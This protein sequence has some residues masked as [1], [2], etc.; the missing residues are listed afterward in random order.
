MKTSL[1]FTAP[2]DL[3]VGRVRIVSDKGIVGEWVATPSQLNMV[4]EAIEPGYYMAEVS[5]AGMRP[6]SV[7]FEVREGQANTVSL[8]DYSALA[9]TGGGVVFLDL[10]EAGEGAPSAFSFRADRMMDDPEFEPDMM[11]RTERRLA[12]PPELCPPVECEPL[13]EH[14]TRLL[15]VAI[16]MERQGRRESWTRFEGPSQVQLSQGHLSIE[17]G[18]PE[19]WTSDSGRRAR[20]SVAIQGV[21]IERLLLPLYRGGTVINVTPSTASS[22]D[23]A[24]EVLP[25]DPHLRALWRALEA[26]TREHAEAVRDQL[27]QGRGAAPVERLDS[28]DPWEAMLAGLLYLR[29]PEVFGPLDLSWAGELCSR[30][31]WAADTHIIHAQQLACSAGETESDVARSAERAIDL[32]VAAQAC[33]SPY[34]SPSNMLFNELV[35]SLHGLRALS[36]RAEKRI[37]RARRRWQRELPLQRRAGAS[38]S[39]LSRDQHLLKTEG[40]LAPRRQT[41]GRLSGR[42][43]TTLFTGRIVAG[44]IALDTISGSA[45]K[46]LSGGG[47]S[48]D[49]PPDPASDLGGSSAPSDCPALKRSSGPPD[50]SNKGR[51]GGEA[52][53]GGFRLKA[54][55]AESASPDWVTVL[56]A[57]ESEGSASPGIGD[58]VWF[59]LHSTF[60]PQWVKVLF[61][62]RRASLAVRV[63][64]GFTVGAWLPAQSVELELDLAELESA[65]KIIRER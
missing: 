32:L 13:A 12:E 8:P 4:S 43:T 19:G 14:E 3:S 39:W 23:V 2:A 45:P 57:V 10:P 58:S 15:S 49:A 33:G 62:G 55:F 61:R 20:L 64:G 47:A 24:L 17:V 5:P 37:D 38:F 63:W 46:R 53:L 59:C 30:H 51:F 54:E 60:D 9:A 31:G 26:G 28:A 29:F 50:D 40:I 7:I 22:F 16:S 11:V 27:L 36:V 21:R 65:P 1:N 25:A 56:L 42:D 41:S 34:F 6:Q 44:A 35:E 18:P 52:V 48:P